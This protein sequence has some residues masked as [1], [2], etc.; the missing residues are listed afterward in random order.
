MPP[1]LTFAA[2]CGHSPRGGC[3]AGALRRGGRPVVPGGGRCFFSSR[4]SRS[5]RATGRR[6]CHRA[7][8]GRPPHRPLSACPRYPLVLLAVGHVGPVPRDRAG[9]LGETPEVEGFSPRQLLI[10]GPFVHAVSSGG[11]QRCRRC[12]PAVPCLSRFRH[13]IPRAPSRTVVLCCHTC[14]GPLACPHA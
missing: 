8:G 10:V 6:R 4:G 13:D 11:R 3:R 9:G 1:G 2:T 12:C 14:A 7:S 5:A